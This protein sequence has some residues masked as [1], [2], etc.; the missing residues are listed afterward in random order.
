[1]ERKPLLKRL[2][3]CALA[4]AVTVNGFII[5]TLAE[6]GSS[7][8]FTKVSND[9]VSAKFSNMEKMTDTET[10]PYLDTDTVRVSIVLDDKSTI[11]AG[12]EVDGV[13]EDSG[14]IGYRQILLRNQDAIVAEIERF[15][16]KDL[17][18]VW[19]LTLAANLISANVEYG[20]IEEIEKIRGVKKVVVETQYYPDVLNVPLENDP[21]MA[22]SGLQT[23]S[24]AAW[25]VGY[26]GAGSRIAVIDT[27][28]DTDHQS[29]AEAGYL[30]SLELIA[31]EKGISLE[32]YM[33][34]LHLLTKAEIDRVKDQ[35]NAGNT[36]YSDRLTSAEAMDSA[37]AYISA[38]LPYAYN[39]VDGNYKVTHD[40]DAAGEHGSHVAGIATANA[41]IKTA[42][43]FEDALDYVHVAGVAPDA[44]LLTMKVFGENG[45]AYDSDYMAAIE[46][47]IILKADSINLSLGSGNPGRSRSSKKVYQDI[48]DDLT[49]SGVVV[50][51]SAGNSGTWAENT[52]T[53]TGLL[54][55]D[56]VSMATNG[57]PGSFTNSLC[58]ASA[59]NIGSTGYTLLVGEDEEP[60]TFIE[61][62]EDIAKGKYNSILSLAGKTLEYVLIDGLGSQED[63]AALGDA[64]E[65]KVAVCKR[66]THNFTEKANWAVEAGAIAT[67]IY[68]N[69][70]G[71]LGG[72]VSDGYKY[73]APYLSVSG[74][75]GA[76]LKANAEQKTAAPAASE[77]AAAE[78]DSTEADSTEADNAAVTDSAETDAAVTAQADG[79][80]ASVPDSDS[81]DTDDGAATD[82]GTA[83]DTDTGANSVPDT[84]EAGEKAAA[85]VY[86]EGTFV[87]SDDVTSLLEDYWQ[88]PQLS[89]VSSFSSWGVPGSLKMKPEITAPGGNIYS[90][91][92]LPEDGKSYENMSGT[93]MASPQ[94][95]GMAA[96]AAQYIR[97]ND[98]ARKTGLSAR[99]LAQSLLMST[100]VP[101]IEGMDENDNLYYYP[102]LRQGAGLADIS[103]V[104]SSESYILMGSDATES[105][106]DGKVKAEL[107]DDPDREGT[108]SFSFTVNNL[109]DSVQ[110]YELSAQM[111]TQAPVPYYVNE[112]K[113]IGYYMDTS[114][115]L[116]NSMASFTC[117]G[118]SATEI[119]VPANDSV[120]VE[121]TLTLS[122]EDKAD[123]DEYFEKGAYL[124]GYV[125]VDSLSDDDGAYGVSHSIPVL[126]FYGNWTDPSMY[127]VGSYIEYK[128]G[129]ENRITYLGNENVNAF[130]ITYA[131]EPGSTYYYGGNPVYA[132]EEYMPERNAINGASTIS[133]VSFA[134]IRNA[135]ASYFAVRSDYDPLA[136]KMGPIDAAF[137]HDNNQRWY[138]TQNTKPIGFTPGA[139]GFEE[140]DSMEL[141]LILAPEYY[142]D[143]EGNVALEKLGEGAFMA[144]PMTVD[145]T[146]PEVTD[147]VLDDENGIL[148]VTAS[149]NQYIAAVVLYNRAGDAILSLAPSKT[150]IA[151]GAEAE[152]DLPLGN[153]KGTEFY[154]QVV[155][156]A[157][158]TVTYRLDEN[159]GE[160]IPLPE[161]IA[162][163]G[164]NEEWLGI[165]TNGSN[166]ALSLYMPSGKTFI[167]ATIADHYVFALNSL[168][169]LYVMP[170]D[171][172]DNMT[173]IADV[174]YENICDMAYNSADG[175]IYAVVAGSQSSVLITIDKL[176]GE[177]EPVYLIPFATNTL[178]CDKSGT[179][180]CN[181]YG[182]DAVAKFNLMLP[183]GEVV[184]EPELLCESAGIG[185][186][187]YLQAMEVNPNNDKLCWTSVN[188]DSKSYYVEIDTATG[189]AVKYNDLVLQLYALIIPDRTVRNYDFT[190]DGKVNEK[191]GLAL[192]DLRVGNRESVYNEEYADFDFDGDIDTHDA[193]LFFDKLFWSAPTSEPTQVTISESTATI[194]RGSQYQLTAT[195]SPWTLTD[196]SIVWTSSDE[197]VATVSANG[198]VTAV[199]V[200]SCTITAAS[201]LNKKVSA[202]CEFNV[203]I[204]DVTVSGAL[205]DD[206]GNPMLFEWNMGED[207]TW[208][209]GHDLGT[210]IL[211]ADNSPDGY[212]YIVNPESASMYK[213]DPA[214]GENMETGAGD[215]LPFSDFEFSTM[216]TDGGVPAI[217]GVY[218]HLFMPPT[219]PMNLVDSWYGLDK[220]LAMVGSSAFIGLSSMGKTDYY[221]SVDD[222]VYDAER[223]VAV[224]D[225]GLLWNLFVVNGELYGLSVYDSNMPADFLGSN[226]DM[227]YCSLTYGDDGYLYFSVCD[228]ST[229][230]IYRIE[231][232]DEAEACNVMYIGNVG[233]DVFH[234]ALLSV[235]SN[236]SAAANTADGFV[237]YGE[238]E[239]AVESINDDYAAA[240]YSLE[241]ESSETFTDISFVKPIN[242]KTEAAFANTF[243]LETVSFFNEEVS[244]LDASAPVSEQQISPMSSAG[245]D[246]NEIVVKLTAQ[247]TLSENVASTNGLFIVEYDPD[248]FSFTH[249]KSPAG[250]YNAYRVDEEAGRAIIAY[251]S[252]YAPIPA[253]EAAQTVEFMVLKSSLPEGTTIDVIHA[254]LNNR[255]YVEDIE[256]PDV[257]VNPDNPGENTGTP[258]EDIPIV[259]TT[260]NG[261]GNFID[262]AKTTEAAPAPEE[263]ASETTAAVTG[264]NGNGSVDT[265]ADTTAVPDTT[266]AADTTTV[267]DSNGNNGD[268]ENTGSADIGSQTEATD[269][270]GSDVGN[271]GSGA[272]EDKN[273]NT[274]MVL[275]F[276]PAAVSA[277]AVLI[278][279]KRRK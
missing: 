212:V 97:Q 196:R 2:L 276:V 189:E 101:L 253:D 7:S 100:A 155:D 243:A 26:T 241:E 17:D 247:N 176:T 90:V 258:S 54:Y 145:N 166:K 119:A 110:K 65:G 180:Y 220:Y 99:V 187:K 82:D 121:V 16:E 194:F 230:N 27:G 30:H 171:D 142:V 106:L 47:A 163:N 206:A 138:Y 62:A 216:F 124:E 46:D 58:V 44:Q 147:I 261:G 233:A 269:N 117:D 207:S 80:N 37:K 244:A 23:G 66:G 116:L 56:D 223:F 214:T 201:A 96:L 272:D 259:V 240:A 151:A 136:V 108:Y 248:T 22:T 45:G 278:S 131:D 105:Y 130:G 197:A 39:Y 254:E 265:S 167:A 40:D 264:D 72:M 225:Q 21:N 275:C 19:N 91:N 74:E 81:A 83:S 213:V 160:N 226:T 134:A 24:F 209:A 144:V 55:S 13:S 224:D 29:F 227:A 170:E 186:A 262:P 198:T 266:T 120:E 89:T 12:Y 77:S 236:A 68:N 279:K 173:K 31:E 126:G 32:D 1:M 249:V 234:A 38:K 229:N 107:G 203:E 118:A 95:A 257:P 57:S 242:E 277:V 172:L 4:A 177:A 76:I 208:T 52:E 271:D 222:A 205:Q 48:M 268:S 79:E 129:T 8:S 61:N 133:I 245:T 182:T 218:R 211:S 195:V 15:L 156:Y 141:D 87:P 112:D 150:D 252:P 162:F 232:D 113:D 3:S 154:V 183:D 193:Y 43:G 200:G 235:T 149:D 128:H 63:W 143:D 202:S 190:N 86:Y 199:G 185:A 71:D 178:A 36:E 238:N 146:E 94:I 231:V 139:V 88:Y 104:V 85:A 11:E 204:A 219:D 49:E 239:F 135:E 84:A 168:N 175:K 5:P 164:S 18:V 263:S 75:A 158:N 122:T 165:G 221:D 255:N 33:D 174:A 69:A 60:I 161:M 98:L 217:A 184:V 111:F 14:A 51:I 270:A 260:A 41:Y 103:A 215:K 53:L 28:T 132:D 123:L 125:F 273:I 152:Y 188:A 70:P 93:S 256:N 228:N 73:K 250:V 153:I 115:A 114:A 9:S 59:D 148:T 246:D 109:T 20:D 237:S 192:L 210:E 10:S 50:A 191:D 34:E 181:L 92:G 35:L 137:Y 78:A 102:V 251:V 267:P 140:G 25:N 42:G 274:G 6:D 127:D 169:E 159:I 64:L 67:I 179:F 157:M